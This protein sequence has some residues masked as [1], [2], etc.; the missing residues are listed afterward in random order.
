MAT[1]LMS[2]GKELSN[3][4]ILFKTFCSNVQNVCPNQNMSLNMNDVQLEHPKYLGGQKYAGDL[5]IKFFKTL[6]S[7]A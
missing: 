5:Q 3:F 1:H 4:K 2:D 6:K 7:I